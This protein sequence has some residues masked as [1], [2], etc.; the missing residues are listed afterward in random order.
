MNIIEANFT[1]TE[2]AHDEI[3]MQIERLKIVIR[4]SKDLKYISIK[5]YEHASKILVEIGKMNGGW[6]KS[7]LT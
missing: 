5:Q 6:K 1:K 2:L 3:D 4:L 7:N